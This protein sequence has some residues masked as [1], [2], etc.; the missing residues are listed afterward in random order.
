[1]EG[2]IPAGDGETMEA[3][4]RNSR[5]ETAAPVTIW[6]NNLEHRGEFFLEEKGQDFRSRRSGQKEG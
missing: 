4:G 1:L 3:V 5:K 2:A 6:G